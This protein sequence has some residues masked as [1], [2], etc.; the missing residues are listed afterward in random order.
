MAPPPPPRKHPPHAP[1]RAATHARPRFRH[2]I[3]PRAP[4]R[5]ARRRARPRHAQ[6]PPRTNHR[7][8]P[9]LV[10]TPP[11]S[12]RAAAPRGLAGSGRRRRAR[13]PR[14]LG[15]GARSR[16]RP[17]RRFHELHHAAGPPRW[18][19]LCLLPE[20]AGQPLAWPKLWKHHG[21]QAQADRINEVA[22]RRGESF[23]AR[24]GGM[25]RPGMV[26]SKNAR[27]AGA[28]ARHLR[29]GRSV[30]R[31]GRL[32]RLAARRRRCRNA[33]ALHLPGRLQ[34]HVERHRWLPLVGFP[35]R[36]APAARPGG[37]RENAGPSARPRHRGGRA[38]R[39]NGGPPRP[40][41]GHPGQRR[42]HRRPRRR[43]R[44]RRRRAGHARHGARH[45]L[46]PHAQQRARAL[47]PRRRRRR[48]AMAS[49]PAT[50][51]T[52]PAR[53]P[54]ATPSIGSAA[55]PASPISPRSIA[56]PPS[57]PPARTASSASIG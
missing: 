26:L 38:H 11:P 46:L 1:S 28:C 9:R 48:A 43:A 54:S 42:H 6:V 14:T 18:P 16:D 12:L 5:S 24:Y 45:Q 47:R 41:R 15:P 4:R 51:A 49:S 33:P 29:S 57:F 2:R 31:S 17:R 7:H 56:P 8:P 44:R 50:S 20:F 13:G 37:R 19:P 53:P 39:G 34:G 32:V 27:D 35:G 22:R 10:Q 23:L 40:R 52:R 21:A 3:R 55:S 30:A 36:G 25:H